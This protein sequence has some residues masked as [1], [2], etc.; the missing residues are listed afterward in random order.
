MLERESAAARTRFLQ[1]FAVTI[2]NPNTRAAYSHAVGV[3]VR[4]RNSRLRFSIEFVGRSAF[5]I[6][7]GNA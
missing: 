3:L 1:D 5:N 2:R 7:L 6:G 4:R